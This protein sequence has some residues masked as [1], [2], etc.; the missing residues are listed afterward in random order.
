MLFGLTAW[1]KPT[2]SEIQ[3]VKPAFLSSR[4][5]SDKLRATWLGHACYYV[6]FPSGLRVLFDPV[7]EN[8]CSPFEKIGP[9]RYTPP[10]CDVAALPHIDAV[11]ISHSHYDHLCK[12]YALIV[13]C[14]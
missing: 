5:A 11:V 3:V 7:F 12:S 10:A 14:A 13:P 8:C 2:G 1:P 4:T 6:E 9:K